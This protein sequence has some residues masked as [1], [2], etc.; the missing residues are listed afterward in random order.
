MITLRRSALVL[1]SLLTIGATGSFA[2]DFRPREAVR[3]SVPSSGHSGGPAT[4]SGN[5]LGV[6]TYSDS[7]VA[8]I[9]DPE[10]TGSLGRGEDAVPWS[11]S[12]R[13]QR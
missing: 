10:A 9:V 8:P 1:A 5:P 4:S 7:V 13:P 6:P 12:Q 11:R 2:Q 3:P